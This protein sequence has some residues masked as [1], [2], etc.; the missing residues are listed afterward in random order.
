MFMKRNN[1][2]NT[3]PVPE[4]PAMDHVQIVAETLN[5]NCFH[6]GDEVRFAL[7]DGEYLLLNER[8]EGIPAYL[9]VNVTPKQAYHLADV[10]AAFTI[11]RGEGTLWK[12]SLKNPYAFVHHGKPGWLALN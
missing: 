8:Y 4:E 2:R 6:E 12:A 9:S 7:I 11:V 3:K 5:R 1:V 10:R